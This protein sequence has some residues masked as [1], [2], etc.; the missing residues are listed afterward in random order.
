[1]LETMDQACL[2]SSDTTSNKRLNKLN[3]GIRDRLQKLHVK[4]KTYG[5]YSPMQMKSVGFTYTDDGDT[6]CCNTCQLVVS[7]WTRDMKPI[8]VH[9]ERSPNCEFIRKHVPQSVIASHNHE[10]PSKRLKLD[11]DLD[12]YRLDL[13]EVNKLRQIRYRTYLHWPDP[14]GPY[15]MRLIIAGFFACSVKDRVICLYCNLILQEWKS[16]IDDPCEVHKTLS[17]NCPFVLSY[18]MES[19]MTSNTNQ[20]GVSII[21]STVGSTASIRTQD[22]EM[23][24]TAAIHTEYSDI[25]KRE[26]SFPKEISESFSSIQELATAGFFYDPKEDIL[27]CFH[28]DGILTKFNA[29]D[30]LII[31]HV[32]YF[33]N[34]KYAQGICGI[35]LYRYI[36]HLKRKHDGKYNQISLF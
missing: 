24:D 32:R 27:R 36:R 22:E 10:T 20:H 7:G 3:S 23:L 9:M 11:S 30:N 18:L 6:V 25:K 19:E 5:I 14:T 17:P 15:V 4:C 33:P 13:I 29:T 34:C 1:M 8:Q 21:H 12:Q 31:D 26:E 28:C 2:K 16:D 35:Q